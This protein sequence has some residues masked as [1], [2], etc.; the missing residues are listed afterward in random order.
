MMELYTNIVGKSRKLLKI[1]KAFL[2]ALTK[3]SIIDI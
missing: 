2:T 3:G 1:L